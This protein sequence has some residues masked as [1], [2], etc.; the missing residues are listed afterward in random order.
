[1]RQFKDESVALSVD[2]E[3]AILCHGLILATMDDFEF[4]WQLYESTS[5]PERRMFYLKVIGCIESKEI[6]MEFMERM[7]ER[8]SEW[9]DILRA[10]C[11]THRIGSRVT[12]EFLSKN[13]DRV[14]GL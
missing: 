7:F 11:C 4:M 1:M 8:K 2:H 9:K 14:I 12:L 10:A 6:L 13:Y 3:S 5:S